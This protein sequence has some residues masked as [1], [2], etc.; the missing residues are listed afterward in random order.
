MYTKNAS[1]RDFIKTAAVGAAIGAAAVP[2]LGF[3]DE[4]QDGGEPIAS[5]DSQ[6][7]LKATTDQNVSAEYVHATP[8]NRWTSE[9][10]AAWRTP[11]DPVSDDEIK[12]AGTFDVVIV[13]GG[14]AGT[15]A[16]KSCAENGLSVAVI[17]QQA[18]ESMQYIGG[19]V[20]TINNKWALEHGADE[21]D[22]QAFMREIFRRN[23]TR[24]NQAF[25]RDYV[26][27]S[28]EI[29]QK[30]IEELGEDW[31]A[32][33]S[34]V[35]SCPHD[36]R[37][38]MDPSGFNFYT[39]TIIFRPPS[40][41][42][43]AWAWNDVMHKM[44]QDA[45]DAGAVWFFSNHAE[46]LEKDDSGRV[47]SAVAK[48]VDDGACQRVA[49]TKAVVLCGGDFNGNTDMLRDIND[50]Y[51]HLAESLGDIEI[52]MPLPIFYSRDG[53]AIAMG[54]WAGGHIEVG[55]HAGMNTGM[56]GIN[57][58]W[59]PGSLTLNQKGK[60]FCDECAGGTEG[61]GYMVPRQ[62]KGSVVTFADA[63]WE[64]LAY[65]MPP[66][67]GAVD[68]AHAN[69][70]PL[71]VETM[72]QVKPGDAP[73]ECSNQDDIYE[74]YCADTMEELVDMVGVWDDE[75][76]ARALEEIERY[77]GMAAA[78]L[79]EDYAKDPRILAVTKLDTPP[80]YAV[81]ASTSAI[82]AGLCQ[83]TGLDVDDDHH[84]VD[85]AR[86]PIPGLFALGNSSG[87]RF[88]VQYATPLSGM[89]LGYCMTEGTLFGERLAAGEIA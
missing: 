66:A 52:A 40:M 10:S 49:A 81:V 26:N 47:V 37:M 74:V 33:N 30:V 31:V 8:E 35:G 16:A 5:K 72:G 12:D 71:L 79:D 44:A 32:E 82:S 63:N 75:Q 62:P 7:K 51:R 64:D 15:W 59:G 9:A 19:E 86:E 70:W 43:E 45:R 18:E 34:H 11:C 13:G 17:E 27:H 2:S 42:R 4:A 20:G 76:K 89:S 73:A 25:I 22:G 68:V 61:I 21:I 84:V 78:G 36:E 55:P 58:P 41:K 88:I 23:A 14:Q 24:S 6:D 85:T 56:A 54:V 29:L 80:F 65:A 3:A 57:T 28:G 1:R 83:T 39:G 69:N 53:S 38:V 46:Y 60:R 50:E 48:N 87:N 67:H 77:Q